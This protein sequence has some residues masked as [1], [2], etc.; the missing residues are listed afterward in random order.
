MESK[1]KSLTDFISTVEVTDW[2]WKDQVQ[3]PRQ[4]ADEE[5]DGEESLDQNGLVIYPIF[6]INYE[7]AIEYVNSVI[8]FCK[9]L[10]P[11]AHKQLTNLTIVSWN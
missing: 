1:L 11:E 5:L 4:Y 6:C 8:G 7:H 10:C 2:E 9:S 3:V